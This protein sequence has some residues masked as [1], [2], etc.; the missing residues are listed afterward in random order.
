VQR[1]LTR[2]NADL[3]TFLYTAS[4]ELKT[5]LVN[6][7]GLLEALQEE[8]PAPVQQD[9]LVPS[10][11]AL[12]R[13]SLD[14][15]QLTLTQLTDISHLQ[16]TPAQPTE[17]VD[18][19][20]LLEEVRGEL[21]PVLTASAAHLTVEFTTCPRVCFAPQPLRT[22]VQHLLSNA[23]HYR[24]PDRAPQIAVRA[25]RQPG[26]TVLEVQDNGLG[27]DA[28]QIPKLFTL[29]QRF[30][31]HV[32]GAGI[33]LYMVQRLLENGGGTITVQSQLGVGSTFTVTLPDTHA[34]GAPAQEGEPLRG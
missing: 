25:Y 31:D 16:R 22:I 20:T 29:F 4:H 34:V 8:L 24:S 19:A 7:E 3:D 1:Q 26:Y 9:G 30:H 5:P 23:L 2:V 21:A 11:L 10:L 32:E 27:L 17:P 13:Q 14:R 6:L 18:W 15:F 33:G 12:M 28:A